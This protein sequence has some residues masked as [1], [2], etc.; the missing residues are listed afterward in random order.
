MKEVFSIPAIRSLCMARCI[1]VIGDKMFAISLAWWVMSSETVPN[2]EITL[3]LLLATSTLPVVLSG[4]LVGPIIDRMNK[5]SCMAAADAARLILMTAL[6]LL[7]HQNALT[8]PVL[9]LLCFLLFALQPL[10][11]AAASASLSPLSTGPIMLAQLVALESAIP[12]IAA[13]LG[14]LFGSF[15][16]SVWNVEGAFWFNASTF[17]V[18]LM[19][20]VQLPVL[21]ASTGNEN[22]ESLEGSYTFLKNWPNAMRLLLLFG[23]INFFI[24]PVFFYLPILTRDVLNGDG[25][26]LGSLELAFAAGNLVLF[27]YFFVRPREF[28]RTRWLRFFLVASSAGFLWILGSAERIGPMIAA[29]AAWGFSVAFVSYL[30]ISSFQRT[31]SDEYKGRFFAIL[32]SLC[33]MA[34]PLSFACFGVLSAHFSLRE[35]IFGNAAC[36]LLVALA[37]LTVPDEAEPE[38]QE[39]TAEWSP[40]LATCHETDHEKERPC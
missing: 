22:S 29:L 9:F 36:A 32:T 25:A 28:S 7:I 24:A 3:G 38:C 20:V 14:A 5:R 16:L 23:A 35:L 2:R 11:D 18:S 12:N 1:S 8:I 10:F 33:T 26:V 27:G 37:F 4:P 6:A 39:D 17:L 21:K 19:F 31:I 34:I 13:V 15:A 30:A 40:L